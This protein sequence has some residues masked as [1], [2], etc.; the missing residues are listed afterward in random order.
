MRC[1]IHITN[2]E[3]SDYELLKKSSDERAINMR[4]LARLVVE[5]RVSNIMVQTANQKTKTKHCDQTQS[6]QLHEFSLCE[7]RKLI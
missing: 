4:K 7:N 6:I 2:G 1:E 3:W 5:N